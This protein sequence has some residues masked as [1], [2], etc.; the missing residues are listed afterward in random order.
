MI[1]FSYVYLL[2]RRT[3]LMVGILLASSCALWAQ[4]DGPGGPPPGGFGEMQ[5]KPSNP[6][7]AKPASI[8]RRR[9]IGFCAA[10]GGALTS[11]AGAGATT[12]GAG[13][14]IAGAGSGMKVV[15]LA[16]GVAAGAVNAAASKLAMGA[17]ESVKPIQSA[18]ARAVCGR[19]SGFFERQAMI[20]AATAGG[21]LFSTSKSASRSES[22]G[23]RTLRTW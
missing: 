23:A 9:R 14:A 2:A 3:L 20:I 11:V 19:F 17:V 10:A 8:T 5:Q 22:G 7:A 16:G 15:F 21:T 4:P 18:T 12:L 13:A 1:E 6:N